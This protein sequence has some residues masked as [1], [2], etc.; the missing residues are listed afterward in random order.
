M[1]NHTKKMLVPVIIAI[2]MTIYYIGFFVAVFL[3]RR[4]RFG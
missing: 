1:K 2:I 3:Y 4:C